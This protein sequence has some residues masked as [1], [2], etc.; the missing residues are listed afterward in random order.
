[1]NKRFSVTFVLEV[2]EDNN[3]LSSVEEAHI[4]DV[5]DLIKDLF[6]DVDDVEVENITVKER[7]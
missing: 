5:Y 6:Y 3:L 2:D 4:D 1:M 7:L